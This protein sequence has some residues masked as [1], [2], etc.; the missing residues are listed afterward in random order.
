MCLLS[1]MEKWSFKF[2]QRL[3]MHVLLIKSSSVPQFSC[4]YMRLYFIYVYVML[5]TRGSHTVGHVAWGA[6]LVLGG[7]SCLYKGHKH[8][9]FGRH[10]ALLKFLL[11]T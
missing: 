3:F 9:H 2:E 5:E 1:L 11:I 4:P 6:L 7:G 8:I 10:F